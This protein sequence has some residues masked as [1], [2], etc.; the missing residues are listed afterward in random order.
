MSNKAKVAVGTVVGFIGGFLIGVFLMLAVTVAFLTVPYEEEPV[1][2]NN[3]QEII[4]PVEDPVVSFNT[5]TNYGNMNDNIGMTNNDIAAEEYS[6][7][8]FEAT[9]EDFMRNPKEYRGTSYHMEN[10]EVIS[11]YSGGITNEGLYENITIDNFKIYDSAYKCYVRDVNGVSNEVI[12]IDDNNVLAGSR[13]LEGDEISS[14]DAEFVNR[15]DG[16]NL[17]VFILISVEQ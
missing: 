12:I 1:A 15:L 2:A 13:W 17:P 4:D 3:Q 7:E 16:F 11:D 14:L 6:E 10:L 8:I 9:I 5:N